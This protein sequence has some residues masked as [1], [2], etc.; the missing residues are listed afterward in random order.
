MGVT[1]RWTSRA[2]AS[3]LARTAL[4]ARRAS[5]GGEPGF[6]PT[7]FLFERIA[8]GIGLAGRLFD[9]KEQLVRRT[10]QLIRGCTCPNG[11]PACVGPIVGDLPEIELELSRKQIAL[12]ILDTLEA[13]ATH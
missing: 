13:V 2:I 1:V 6:N 3:R 8:G 7:I 10:R 12:D 11:C 5:G 4:T 9:E